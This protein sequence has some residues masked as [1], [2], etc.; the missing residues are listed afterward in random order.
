MDFGSVLHPLILPK[1]S[2]NFFEKIN[3][4]PK[5]ERL[6]IKTI[7]QSFSCLVKF[8][9]EYELKVPDQVNFLFC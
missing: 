5:I 9:I 3:L 2:I 8:Y 1:L 4:L 7:S 6:I